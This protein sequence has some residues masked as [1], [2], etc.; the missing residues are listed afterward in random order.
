MTRDFLN[1]AGRDL[2]RVVATV[3]CR[4]SSSRLP[5]KVLLPAGGYPLLHLLAQRLERVPE[6][7]RIVLATT[8][9]PVDDPIAELAAR[10]DIGCWRGSE[11]DVLRRV[12]DAASHAGADTIV[13]ITGDCPLID[14]SIVSQAIEL[15]RLNDCD[16]ASNID[17]RAFPDGM[18]VQVFSTKL[19]QQAGAEDLSPQDREHVSWFIRRHPQRYKKL[20]LPAPPELRWPE[21]GLTL[22]EEADYR[23]IKALFEHFLPAC[24]DFSCLDMVRLLRTNPDLAGANASV[25][26]RTPAA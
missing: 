20:H 22:D 21:L 3:E 6:I 12:L 25:K 19:L 11:E 2:G 10:L 18:D 14:P 4:M 17:P 23:L 5:G 9:N 8:A 7:H 26:R 16:Y 13:E 15:Y 24:P 1:P